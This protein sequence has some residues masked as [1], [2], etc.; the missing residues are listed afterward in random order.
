MENTLTDVLINIVA[1]I[2]GSIV[3]YYAAKMK[4]RAELENKA[5][6]IE[7]ERDRQLIAITDDLRKE[8]KTLKTE[9]EETE[10]RRVIEKQEAEQRH[11]EEKEQLKASNKKLSDELTAQLDGQAQE[12]AEMRKQAAD[13]Q[14]IV[15]DQGRKLEAQDLDI[16][17]LQTKVTGLKALADELSQDRNRLKAELDKAIGERDAA[18]KA[19]IEKDGII[20]A[21]KAE[22]DA[23]IQDFDTRIKKLEAAIEARDQQIAS[24]TEQVQKLTLEKALEDVPTEPK[25]SGVLEFKPDVDGTWKPIT[26]QDEKPSEPPPPAA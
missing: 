20:A 4:G 23:L 17:E 16:K 18:L 19:S 1:V 6:E 2:V 25:P 13:Y 21:L 14:K 8:I 15:L 12:R 10:R 24:L 5:R 26:P 11:A 9:A 7:L 22:K 3:S